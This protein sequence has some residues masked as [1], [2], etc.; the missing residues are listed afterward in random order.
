MGGRG[1]E[2]KR[3][4]NKDKCNCL[5]VT[6]LVAYLHFLTI[7][8]IQ[9]SCLESKFNTENVQLPWKFCSKVASGKGHGQL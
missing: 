9:I 1:Q 6:Y 8:G 2:R 5:M 3:E 7:L 4:G